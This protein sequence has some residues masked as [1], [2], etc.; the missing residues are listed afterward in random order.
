MSDWYR[1]KVEIVIRRDDALYRRI[2][3]YA[4]K[5]NTTVEAVVDTLIS[6][7]AYHTMKDRIEFLER[8]T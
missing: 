4:E 2:V 7:G 3:D 5:H 8:H 6:L 1:Q